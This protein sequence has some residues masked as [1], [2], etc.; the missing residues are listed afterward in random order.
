MT[1]NRPTYD[2]SLHSVNGSTIWRLWKSC[3][4]LG[5]F[6]PV[7]VLTTQL[8][9]TPLKKHRRS[10][11]QMQ[12]VNKAVV[13]NINLGATVLAVSS[14]LDDRIYTSKEEQKT[15]LKAVLDDQRVCVFTP[16]WLCQEWSI[17]SLELLLPG[18]T[19]N[20]NLIGPL[21]MNVI[22]GSSSHLRSPNLSMCSFLG[23]YIK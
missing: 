2:H 6:S 14:E 5:I 1:Q 11:R 7:S 17:L 8:L 23:G 22:E 15:T 19:V 9:Q 20:K 3:C 18:S 4:E 12:N 10:Q 16:D 21:W 13:K